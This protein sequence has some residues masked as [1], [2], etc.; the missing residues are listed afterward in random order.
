LLDIFS[1]GDV[2][3]FS[4]SEIDRHGKTHVAQSNKAYFSE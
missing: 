3:I 2:V 1:E 4:L